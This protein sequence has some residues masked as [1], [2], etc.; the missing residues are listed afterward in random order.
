MKN[1]INLIKN[2]YFIFLLC[3]MSLVSIQAQIGEILWE[4]N[5]DTLNADYWTIDIGDGC[6]QGI[7]G[8]GNQELQSYQEGNVYIGDVP[9]EPGNKALILE[10]KRENAGNSAFTSGKI[11]SENRVA[12]HYGLV[13]VRVR[14][15]NLE[16]GMNNGNGNSGNDAGGLWPAAWMLGTANIPWPSKGEIDI[17][18]MGFNQSER[19]RQGASSSTVNN[20][21][22]ANAFFPIEGNGGVG[23]IA[24]DV[25]YNKPYVATTPINNRFLTYRIYWEPTQ[26]RYTVID[27]STEYDLYEAPFPINPDQLETAPFTRPFYMLLN[28]AVGGTLPGVTSPSQIN[29]PADAKMYVDYVRVSKWNGHGEVEFSDGTV[30]P[31]NGVYG[32]YTETTPFNDKL[33][34]GADGQIY[35]FSNTLEGSNEAPFEGQEVLSFTK[36]NDP[37]W[38]GMGIASLAGKNMSNYAE[39]G[40]LKFRIKIPADIP[41]II[42]LN[43]NFTNAEDITFPA[44]ETKYGLVRNGEWGQ[45]TIPIKD[46]AG[47]LAFQDMQYLFR[48]GSVGE[49]PRT[50]FSIAIDDIY[51]EILSL[52]PRVFI[53]KLVRFL[54][55]KK[56]LKRISMF[57]MAIFSI[58]FPGFQLI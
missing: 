5:F 54:L 23:N 22:G 52:C 47:T 18:E 37:K 3:T 49:A 35:V 25:D 43:D 30:P 40:F 39:E 10:A 56:L 12:I 44:N 21:V 33:N 9:G 8:W 14:V 53:Y 31:E 36:T 27:G 57:S 15:P 20:Y 16:E 6:D 13:E 11:I 2:Q 51:W 28:L 17:M 42:G 41:F 32:V 46:F 26:L 55:L 58:H 50:N 48:I 19:T 38:F 4:D 29:I 45:V 34:F 7:C 24:F 1:M